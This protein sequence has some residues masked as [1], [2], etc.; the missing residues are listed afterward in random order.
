[1]T[2]AITRK[3]I[4][5]RLILKALQD[6]PFKQK[7]F[8]NPRSVLESEG[9]SLPINIEIY[10][11]EESPINLYLVIPVQAN[12]Q[13]E[14]S[15]LDLESIIGGAWYNARCERIVENE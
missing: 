3:E 4:E 14:L 9:I 1:M 5:E 15:E 6:K 7:L 13:S 8:S 10:V 2:T 12:S 11:I